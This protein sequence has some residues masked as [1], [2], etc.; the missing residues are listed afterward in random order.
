MTTLLFSN[1]MIYGSFRN[2]KG[3]GIS[4]QTSKVTRHSSRANWN[5]RNLLK[6]PM[7]QSFKYRQVSDFFLHDPSG[8]LKGNCLF[9]IVFISDGIRNQQS[10]HFFFFLNSILW[11]IA[12]LQREFN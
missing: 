12:V 11:I 4:L 10:G 3:Y 2:T 1:R 8:K 9:F 6:Y 7:I 5:G